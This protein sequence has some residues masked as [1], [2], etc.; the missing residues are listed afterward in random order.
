MDVFSLCASTRYIF[1]LRIILCNSYVHNM[2][3]WPA[4]C[5]GW[6]TSGSFIAPTVRRPLG[7][8]F[9]SFSSINQCAM[10]C[11]AKKQLRTAVAI[12]LQLHKSTT[13]AGWPH[14][15]IPVWYDTTMTCTTTEEYSSSIFSYSVY[16]CNIGFVREWSPPTTTT[17]RN[18]CNNMRQSR[19]WAWLSEPRALIDLTKHITR[20]LPAYLWHG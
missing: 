2:H 14:D 6:K 3:V 10:L 18:Y 7:L 19:P 12:L 5:T 11:V 15:I 13:A 8:A 9:L 1:L 16:Y 20:S 17:P 4:L